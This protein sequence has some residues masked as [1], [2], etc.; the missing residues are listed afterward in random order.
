MLFSSLFGK[1]KEEV[2]MLILV[3]N[4]SI[5]VALA[6][7]KTTEIP[8]FLYC[9]K[10][11][12]SIGEKINTKKRQEEL[13][14]FLDMALGSLMKNAWKHSYWKRK[15]KKIDRIVLTFSPPWFDLKTSHISIKKDKSFIL[16]KDFIEDISIKEEKMF[17]EELNKE[18]PL[19]TKN[20][21]KVIESSI[22]H[23]KINGYD[24]KNIIGK[25]TNSFDA[26]LC[27]SV[28]KK[29]ILDK[30]YDI[31]HKHTL[32]SNDKLLMHTFP[33][34]SFSVVRD[35][36]AY[37]SDFILMNVTP[38]STDLTLV[39][40]DVI[41]KTLT[42]PCGRNFI[43]RQIAKGFNVSPLI[44]ESNL[45]LYN[46]RKVDDSMILQ[47]EEILKNVEKEWSEYFESSLRELFLNSVPTSRIYLTADNDVVQ[48]YIEFLKLEKTDSTM[49]F[50]KDINIIYVNPEVLSHQYKSS[51]HIK[52]DE[53][54]AIIALFYQ[55][56]KKVVPLY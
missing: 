11:P 51:A 34:V 10:V 43:I 29:E 8:E 48:F 1:K 9:A 30:V 28:I 46:S 53:F 47:T 15:Q 14:T 20:S 52:V 18:N 26:Y 37:E 19:L 7:F 40:G 42:F 27:V 39:S 23:T 25:K 24:V 44:A 2:C 6:L 17:E 35:V 21:H 55:K 3:G 38:E 33:L 4:G 50:R 45:Q 12:S 36:L 5:S 13:A 32:I 41:S 54:V 56:V 31:I 22:I 49:A 16:S